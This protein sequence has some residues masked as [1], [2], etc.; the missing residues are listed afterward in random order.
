MIEALYI[1]ITI[2]GIAVIRNVQQA[3]ILENQLVVVTRRV[4]QANFCLLSILEIVVIRR[5][6]QA[7]IL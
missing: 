6:P 2:I 7:K 3:K 5:A 1:Y 4:A